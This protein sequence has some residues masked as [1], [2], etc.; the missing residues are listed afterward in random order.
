MLLYL[1]LSVTG[2]LAI[3]RAEG[4][5]AAACLYETASALGTVGLSLGIT[6]QLGLLS[7]IVLMI[8]MFLGRVG[9][10]TIAYAA[11]S[12]ADSRSSRFPHASVTVG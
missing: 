12:S 7:R 3:S 8:L 2:A 11:F 9:S 5:P 6:A 10:L 4:I 1:I